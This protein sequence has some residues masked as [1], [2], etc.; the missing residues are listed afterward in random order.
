M[1]AHLVRSIPKENLQVELLPTMIAS[2]ALSTLLVSFVTYVLGAFG[3]TRLVQFTPT[4]VVRGFLACVGVE[5]IKTAVENA[6]GSVFHEGFSHNIPLVFRLDFWLWLVPALAV[7]VPLYTLKRYNIIRSVF[8]F[9]AFLIIPIVAFYSILFVTGTTLQEAR[10]TGWLY[11]EARSGGCL[12]HWLAFD[13][14]NV[15]YSALLG[16]SSYMVI[17][18]VIV[19][20]D[21]LL[22]LAG[23][24]DTL[25]IDVDFDHEFRVTGMA[26]S[27]LGFFLLPPG[28]GSLKFLL[29]NHSV[30]GNVNS[31]L[32]AAIASVFNFCLFLAGFP[33][34]NYLPRFFLA[35][36][37]IYA[38][39]AFVVENLVDSYQFLTKK[40]YAVVWLLVILHFF[41]P[42]VL[43]IGVGLLLASG[44]FVI[45]YATRCPIKIYMSGADYRAVTRTLRDTQKLAQLGNKMLTIVRLQGYIFFGT[46]SQVLQALE[47]LFHHKSS[48][49]SELVHHLVLDF[50]EVTGVDTSSHAVFNKLSRQAKRHNLV[51]LW[52]GLNYRRY[53]RLKQAQVLTSAVTFPDLDSAVEWCEDQLLSFS[54]EARSRWLL[55]DALCYIHAVH[56]VQYMALSTFH[57]L[58]APSFVRRFVNYCEPRTLEA[59]DYLFRAGDCVDEFHFVRDGRLEVYLSI[60]D[61]QM[62]RIGIRTGG[63]FLNVEGFWLAQPSDHIVRAT[64]RTRLWVLNRESMRDM[65]REAPE[66]AIQVRDSVLRHTLTTDMRL[67]RR[68]VAFAK[69]EP[70]KQTSKSLQSWRPNFTTAVCSI[71]QALDEMVDQDTEAV[72]APRRPISL[73]AD[74]EDSYLPPLL[75]GEKAQYTDFFNRY[76]S[77]IALSPDWMATDGSLVGERMAERAKLLHKIRLITKLQAGTQS[78]RQLTVTGYELAPKNV[79]LKEFLECMRRALLAPLPNSEKDTLW[80][81]FQ[82]KANGSDVIATTALYDMCTPSHGSL[83]KDQLRDLV[84]E[85]DDELGGAITFEKVLHLFSRMRRRQL[86][87]EQLERAFK[88]FLPSGWDID[89]DDD[90]D[91]SLSSS[92]TSAKCITSHSLKEAL[93]R[94]GVD[95][96]DEAVEGM[97]IEADA[98]NDKLVDFDEFVTAVC[99]L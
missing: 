41:M 59:K 55:T 99:T 24:E 27:V 13:Y 21:F 77:Q 68:L 10:H 15:N 53:Q 4:T 31:R 91:F 82:E 69:E 38:A 87:A 78:E 6:T 71:P 52:T 57:G 23:T 89:S 66:L 97:M 35:G 42:L 11:P 81:M 40:E 74:P 18:I 61:G 14:Q 64:E 94:F 79:T 60:G 45:Q 50:E 39:L 54:S 67:R 75:S 16:T 88:R 49:R 33:L 73:S 44:V 29:L 37:F 32:P 96:S 76:A 25:K 93:Q 90:M 34:I 7:G 2:I 47:P 63:T 28:Y 19:A 80:N 95:S 86:F 43:E 1:A 9:P 58:V 83:S 5:I 12:D 70:Q 20:I 85:V 26:N 3:W 17:M 62:R 51:I 98:N 56:Y 65:E 72:A 92:L 48:G 8:L 30:V 46:A 84:N 22:K 36:L